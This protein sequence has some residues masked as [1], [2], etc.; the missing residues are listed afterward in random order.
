MNRQPI[1]LATGLLV[2]LGGLWLPL[3]GGEIGV[4]ESRRPVIVELFTSE[5]CSSC[6]AA[7]GML[8]ELQRS[9]P[10]DGVEIIGLAQH[11]DYWNDGGWKDRFSSRQFTRRQRAYAVKFKN[12]SAYTPQ[13]VIA[14]QEEFV[15]NDRRRAVKAIS[16]WAAQ[17]AGEV[18]IASLEDSGPDSIS[19]R[20]RIGG[21]PT[22][23]LKADV[24]L[25]VVEGGLAS[26]ITGGENV[27]RS[28][29]HESVVREL[30]TIAELEA[31][32]EVTKL[33]DT[34]I[35]IASEWKRANL[36]AVVFV[37][38]RKTLRILGAA[39]TDL[40]IAPE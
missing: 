29:R 32:S 14:G 40:D 34:A 30:R 33:L 13:L 6:P 23:S 17:P 8:G 28:L 24:L 39:V 35:E 11:V 36:R 10:V 7:D 16:R 25:A 2:L 9:Q 3:A 37:Q 21:L 12:R 22:D 1:L 38:E 31:S 5:G 26:E 19:L 20:I 4:P 27:G 15:G 18:T